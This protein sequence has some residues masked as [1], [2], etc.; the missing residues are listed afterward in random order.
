MK[1][2]NH[3]AAKPPTP[4]LLLMNRFLAMFS[5]AIAGTL[6]AAAALEL[7]APFADHMIL[8][9]GVKVPVWGFDRPG[10]KITVEFAGQG[11]TAT[12]DNKGE[13][14]LEL[15]PLAA[16]AEGRLFKASNSA[17]EAIE[18]KDAL[19]GEVWH[20]S[21]QSNMEWVAAKSMCGD[22]ARRLSAT[23]PEVP[24]REFRTDTVS[25]LYPQKR[26]TSEKGWKTS[27]TAG[28]FSA[29]ALSFAYSLHQ[30]LKVPV[31]IL[32][33]SHSNTR[34]E[35]FAQRAA[36]EQDPRL[37]IDVDLIH[38][39]DVTTAQGR[40]A[41]EKY[42]Q[43]L[44][45][46]Q[47]ASAVLGFPVEKPLPRP[48]LPGIAGQWRG[49]TQFFNGKISPIV[50][51]AIRGSLWCQGESNNG[52]GSLYAARL[53]AL[54]N[55]WRS[56]WGMP[57][58]PF[59]FTQMQVYGGA[60]NPDDLGMAEVSQAQLM[61]FK[62]NRK[63][64]GM[65]VQIDLNPAAPG[66]IHYQNK[67]HPGMRLAR[68]ALARDYGKDIPYT[69]PI[70]A[71]YEIKG[72][73]VVVSFEKDSLCGGLMIGSKG[74]EKD[75]REPDKYVEPARPT[76]GE[77][78]NHFRLCGKDRRWHAAEARIAGDTVVVTSREVPEP[79]GV[80]Y[81]YMAAPLH[82]NLYNQA[83]LPA[84]PFAAIDG[85]LFF[86]EPQ[87]AASAPATPAPPRP[88]L[89]LSPI[90]RDGIILQRDQPIQVW[91]FANA[92]AK[93]TVKLGEATAT[94][95]A[96]NDEF[97]ALKLPAMK[98]TTT[99]IDLS[100]A[101]DNGLQVRVGNILVGDVWFITGTTLLTSE[102]AWNSR[103][104]AAPAPEPLPLVREFRR[105]TAA[106]SSP[107]PRKRAFEIGGDRKYRSNWQPADPTAAEGGFTMFAYHFA[108]TLNRT[109]IPQG[110]VT[111]SSG[112]GGRGAQ[113]ASPLSWT[114]YH[115]IKDTAHPA[116]RPRV[117][118]LRL[119]D[120]SS[121]VAK[122]AIAEYLSAVRGTVAQIADMAKAGADMATAPLM[123]PAFP[124]PERS[125]SVPADAIPTSAYNWCVSPF[126]P[127]AVAGVIWVPGEAN[128]G[129]H[130][131]D[132]AAEVE[133]YAKSLPITYGQ[134][135]VP[136][137]FAQ[138]AATLVN[139][140]TA[141][142]IPGAGSVT[143][144][145]WPKSLKDLAIEMAKLVK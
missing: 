1:R 109:G 5:C 78:L 132:Y 31:G 106:S 73:E 121:D 33:T 13:W 29:L 44:A 32:L 48:G 56:A 87:P 70:Y 95:T 2:M 52:D 126:T 102:G 108:K 24:I 124:E 15:D 20:A 36:F 42:Y 140:I 47:Q 138:P 83:G 22:L 59:Y 19:V 92:G 14:R 26:V 134:D 119:R 50:P 82:A 122:K 144:G 74:E 103:D 57:D 35:A 28:E 141:P 143:F 113:Q 49:P 145:Q 89:S 81:A 117:D 131:V 86:P 114:A 43:D 129:H 8:Q 6:S 79:A 30:E 80:Q 137:F 125:T 54:A 128:I 101:A 3:A 130:P 61:F 110:F 58:M 23:T 71:G 115:A 77:K 76:P 4:K 60:P 85:E 136:F 127:L 100:V 91:G 16:A 68:W 64:T 104:P 142:S 105:K 107:T 69:G 55:G 139:G 99:P 46:W 53:E 41:F 25:A 7:A 66:N 133:T 10:A 62:N 97:W 9:R 135:S 65:V 111:M 93:V 40:A 39:G 112:Q 72:N 27:R 51:F 118:A 34:A 75:F 67:L 63:N 12:A 38:D 120:P 18:I 96:A 84:S 11:K 123:F 90:F 45:D 88:S 98:A 17:G 94:A 21:G 116:F 37:K